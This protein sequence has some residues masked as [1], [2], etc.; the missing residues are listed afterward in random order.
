VQVDEQWS[1]VQHKG[2]QRWLWYAMDAVTGIILAFVLGKRTDEMC[3]ELINKLAIF[4][5]KNI[6]L[7]IMQATVNSSR[8][9]DMWLGS[10]VH[11][12]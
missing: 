4:K 6:T 3:K 2:N 7:T 10:L 1:F 8:P 11:R 5:I 9:I 12:K